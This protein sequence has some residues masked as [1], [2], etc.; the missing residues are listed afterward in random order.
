MRCQALGA[1]AARRSPF[2][3]CAFPFKLESS[4]EDHLKKINAGAGRK[5]HRIG[6]EES[7][8]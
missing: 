4:L 8:Q 7:M 3:T 6:S 1:L 2:V 5:V